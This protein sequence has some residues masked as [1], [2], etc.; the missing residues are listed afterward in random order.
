MD[1][2]ANLVQQLHVLHASPYE[3]VVLNGQ[4]G[5][6]ASLLFAM[7]ESSFPG[8]HSDHPCTSCLIFFN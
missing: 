8:L 6:S 3:A 5:P 1:Q 4:I 2:F 7:S